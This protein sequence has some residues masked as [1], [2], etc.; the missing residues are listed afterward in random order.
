MKLTYLATTIAAGL[1]LAACNQDTAPAAQAPAEAAAPAEAQPEAVTSA[2]DLAAETE[3]VYGDQAPVAI[4]A[5]KPA[6][7][8]HAHNADG[9]HPTGE[10]HHAGEDGQEHGEDAD[11]TH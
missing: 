4:P 8:D 5:E 3:A 1:L 9:S 11:H 2:A 6:E 10:D 7:D